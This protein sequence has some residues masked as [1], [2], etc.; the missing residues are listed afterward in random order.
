[1][2]LS[3]TYSTCSLFSH[4][5]QRERNSRKKAL[6]KTRILSIS[7]KLNFFWLQN[8]FGKTVRQDKTNSNKNIEWYLSRKN[9]NVSLLITIQQMGCSTSSYNYLKGRKFRR[10][11]K[12]LFSR[13][14]NFA[15]QRFYKIS[16][17]LWQKSRNF[18]S[19]KISSFKVA[20][21]W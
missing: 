20:D 3:T 21:E 14:F 16:R 4:M 5:I 9:K 13:E 17:K 18:L 8:Y 6:Y 15:D 1:M 11:P 10:W 2:V 12:C 7:R 19:A